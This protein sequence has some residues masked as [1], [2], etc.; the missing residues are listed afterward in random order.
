MKR[1]T[2]R[3]LDAGSVGPAPRQAGAQ[4]IGGGI[5]VS[6]A[7]W[8]VARSG[9]S[10]APPSSA[11]L[12]TAGREPGRSG[13]RAEMW[14]RQLLGCTPSQVRHPG[15]RPGHRW[16]ST[17]RWGAHCRVGSG[18]DRPP[19]GTFV[20]QRSCAAKPARRGLPLGQRAERVVVGTR[21]HR[22][23]GVRLPCCAWLLRGLC[24]GHDM[25]PVGMNTRRRCH[26]LPGG[27]SGDCGGA[28]GNGGLSDVIAMA[29][30]SP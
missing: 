24:F 10:P 23:A 3:L 28:G 8:A 18:A 1:S 2:G 14:Y 4:A 26:T 25:P 29:A 16:S 27:A 9:R 21:R 13:P 22:S 30:I 17:P 20:L 12:E 11:R 5:R 19:A 15:G 6:L 7:G